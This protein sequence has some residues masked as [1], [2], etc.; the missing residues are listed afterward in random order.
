MERGVKIVNS[1][2]TVCSFYTHARCCSSSQVVTVQYRI[3]KATKMSKH[4]YFLFLELTILLK[5]LPTENYCVFLFFFQKGTMTKWGKGR[6][7]SPKFLYTT[8]GL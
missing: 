8:R 6:V 7:S 5:D 3:F 2:G 4:R 1:V